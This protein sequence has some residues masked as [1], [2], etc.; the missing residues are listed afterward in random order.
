[1][2]ALLLAFLA[3][4]IAPRGVAAAPKKQA[5]PVKDE[6]AASAVAVTPMS[7][8]GLEKD[9]VKAAND[10]LEAELS[11]MGLLLVFLPPPKESKK[12]CLE[13]PACVRSLA[14]GVK[15]ASILNVQIVRLGPSVQVTAR[16][17]RADTGAEAR[18]GTSSVDSANFPRGWNVRKDI[19][20]MLLAV[21]GSLTSKKSAP[22]VVIA[23]TPAA[24]SGASAKPMTAVS[25]SAPPPAKS[26]IVPWVVTGAGAILAAGGGTMALID[27]RTLSD[28]TAMGADKERARQ[29]GRVGLGVM[30]VGV[31]VAVVGGILM[32]SN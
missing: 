7:V 3:A 12:N 32:R 8:S 19:G 31:A 25:G 6:A 10:R 2:S 17:L 4:A 1:M 28:A 18:R 9:A 20:D 30:S 21:A 11:A 29:L 5:P 16:V 14:T 27:S 24:S 26:S 22:T 23:A 15:V 13:T